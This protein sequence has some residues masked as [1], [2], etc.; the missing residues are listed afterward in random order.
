[1][2]GYAWIYIMDGIY[3]M[4]EEQCEHQKC[5]CNVECVTMSTMYY[6]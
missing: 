6:L 1:M 4:D 3:I 2:H 5:V